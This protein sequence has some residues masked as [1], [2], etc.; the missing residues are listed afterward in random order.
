MRSGLCSAM[1]TFLER[2]LPLIAALAV[3]LIGGAVAAVAAGGT[4]AGHSPAHKHAVATTHKH[5][6]SPPRGARM[7]QAAAGYIG[8]PV[9]TLQQDLRSGKSL[10]QLATENG[11]S[12]AGL[13]QALATTARA[14]LEQRLTQA[15]KQ[16]GGLRGA[17]HARVHKL[18]LVAASYLGSTQAELDTKLHSGLTLAQVADATA[19]RSRAGLIAAL[20]AAQPPKA[21]NPLV[22]GSTGQAAARSRQLRQ[23][24]TAFVN[25]SHAAKPARAPKSS[26]GR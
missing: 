17:G 7:L 26:V 13:V 24:I 16:P 8:I 12:E 21:A 15:V 9:E 14:G 2:R 20:L 22:A 1:S 5:A 18:R 11:K 4:S 19:G 23:R 3:L 6:I 10:G 25:R